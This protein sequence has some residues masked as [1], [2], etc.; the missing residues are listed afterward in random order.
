M[1]FGAVQ[2]IPGID[3]E[4]TPTSLKAGISTG[5]DI[6]FRDGLVE[7]MT[8]RVDLTVVSAV[9]RDLHAWQ[10]LNNIDHLLVGCTS[11]LN[12]VTGLSMPTT[13]NITPQQLS[14]FSAPN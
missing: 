13:I 6:R 2:L 10:D 8:G 5:H 7:K 14:T 3:V 9:P 11:G 1:P 4:R 12:V